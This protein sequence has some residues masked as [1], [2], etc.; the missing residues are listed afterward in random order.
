[1]AAASNDSFRVYFSVEVESDFNVDGDIEMM[2]TF[3]SF[4]ITA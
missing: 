1:M 4:F 2:S 3:P